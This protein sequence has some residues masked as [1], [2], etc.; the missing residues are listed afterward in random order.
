MF[1]DFAVRGFFEA[2][3]YEI[4]LPE[5]N[6]SN[7]SFSDI[8]PLSFGF[9]L[10]FWLKTSHAGFF[11]EYKVASEQGESLLLGFYSGNNTFRVHLDKR[12]RYRNCCRVV[13][14]V[15]VVV[16]VVVV[17]VVGSSL[18]SM[19]VLVSCFII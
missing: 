7:V 5:A 3:D 10:C 4:H 17:V 1:V 2:D 16:V 14:G 19:C 15:F 18:V 6:I 13:F 8:S 9:T 12:A 11:I